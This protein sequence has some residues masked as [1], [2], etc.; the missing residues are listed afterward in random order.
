VA[1]PLDRY[2]RRTVLA[3]LADALAH[4]AGAGGRAFFPFVGS[5]PVLPFQRL[6]RAAG[7]AVPG[8]LGLQIH[9]VFGPWWAYRALLAL[10]QDATSSSG[11]F[12]SAPSPGELGGGCAGC[13][14]P[15]VAACPGGAV[16]LA[17]FSV[18]ACHQ[19]RRES[20]PCQLSCPARIRCVRAPE[21]R[22]TD[23]QLAFHMSAAMPR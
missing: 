22:Y 3:A 7:L 16:R 12:V 8:P 18:V 20:P 17:G 5:A 14:A 15:C 21:H 10:R 9:P 13:D 1:D 2:T 4:G 23:D 6:G 19:H 11:A